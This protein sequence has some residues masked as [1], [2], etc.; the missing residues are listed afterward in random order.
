MLDLF[1]SVCKYIHAVEH[2]LQ[3]TIR[4]RFTLSVANCIGI[5]VSGNFIKQVFRFYCVLIKLMR[6]HSMSATS[7]TNSLSSLLTYRISGVGSSSAGINPGPNVAVVSLGIA[8]HL[9][10]PSRRL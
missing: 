10:N 5:I 9:L 1:R 6:F 2:E 3:G 4:Y 7:Y 8:H